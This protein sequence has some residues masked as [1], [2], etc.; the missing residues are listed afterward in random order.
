MQYRHLFHAGNFADVHKHVALLSLATALQAKPRGFLL[1]DTHAGEGLYDLASPEARRGAESLAGIARLRRAAADAT[2]LHPAIA[3]Y[4]AQV[5]RWR[6]LATGL[7]QP[8]PGSPL[9]A[10]GLLRDVDALVAVESQAHVAR[11]LQRH[12]EAARGDIAS[13]CR[14]ITG[15]GY[16]QL[17][18]LLPP[19][20]RRG[21]ILIDPPYER[22][23][24]ARNIATALQEALA[25]FGTGVYALW[26][27]IKRRRDTDLWLARVTRGLSRPHLAAELC[28]RPADNAA[29][30]NGSGM[31]VVNPPWRFDEEARQWQPQL[32]SLLGG[33]G[34]SIVRWLA[35]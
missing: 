25:R 11:A 1:L 14:V 17:R 8:C 21:L 32:L 4:L 7:R 13:P 15:D 30:L 31:L 19:P 23:D 33:T 20:Q 12:I 29:G 26:Y 5:E 28:L 35:S 3:R 2:D 24:E 10:A 27:P 16:Q 6:K 9:L 18:A 34:G 22:T